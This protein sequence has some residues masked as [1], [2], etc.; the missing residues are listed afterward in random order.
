MYLLIAADA[1]AF[2]LDHNKQFDVYTD[3]SDFLLG[4][5]LIQEE[6]PVA[7]LSQKLTKSQQNFTMMEKE[8]LSIVATLGEYKLPWSESLYLNIE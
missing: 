4:A 2:Y 5:C 7:Y 6:S 8:M 1:L 3:A